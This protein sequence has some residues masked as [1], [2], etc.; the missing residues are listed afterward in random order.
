M[1][2]NTEAALPVIVII[3]V[4][5]LVV[6]TIGIYYYAIAAGY[7]DG[8]DYI[9]TLELTL[10]A[11]S[12]GDLYDGDIEM[13]VESADFLDY[14][15]SPATAS[16]APDVGFPTGDQQTLKL[17][18]YKDDSQGDVLVEYTWKVGN[19]YDVRGDGM[20][21]STWIIDLPMLSD[22]A[23]DDTGAYYLWVRVQVDGSTIG[24]KRVVANP[25]VM[26]ELSA[27]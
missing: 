16:V 3:V 11:R 25:E 19:M 12:N 17:W 13:D 1:R 8:D 26:G 7:G 20:Q 21:E 15:F 5:L 18:V 22:M 6:A 4:A 10:K 23:K 2:N 27:P 9:P 24:S 14:F